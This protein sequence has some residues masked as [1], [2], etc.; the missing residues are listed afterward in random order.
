[1]AALKRHQHKPGE[2]AALFLTHSSFGQFIAANIEI[3]Q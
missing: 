1:L 3:N 2:E